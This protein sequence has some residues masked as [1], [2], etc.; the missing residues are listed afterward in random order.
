MSDQG[1][2][3]KP[4]ADQSGTGKA[5]SNQLRLGRFIVQKKLGQGAFGTV[6]LGEDVTLKRPVALK[7]FEL[8][9]LDKD[10]KK[11]TWLD[12]FIREAR[13]AAQLMHPSIT[14]VFEVGR[15][16]DYVYIAM[17]LIENGNL[18]EKVKKEGPLDF[19]L[20]CEWCA[21][22]AEGLDYAHSKGITHRDIKPPNLMLTGSNHCKL[23]DFGLAQMEDPD[24]DFKLPFKV[25]GTPY[26]MAPEV[27]RGK[28]GKSADIFALGAVFWFLLTGKPPFP[29]KSIKDVPKVHLE[30]PLPDLKSIRPDV[31]RP[32]VAAVERALAYKEED[33]F[34]TPG[35]FAKEL[36]RIAQIDTSD[37]DSPLA[38][39]HEA[40][41]GSSIGLSSK[42]LAPKSGADGS[43]SGSRIPTSVDMSIAR[44]R[45]NTMPMWV[46]VVAAVLA[47]LVFVVPVVML[48]KGGEPE[49]IEPEL[50]QIVQTPVTPN[51]TQRDPVQ[52]PTSTKPDPIDDP[53]PVPSGPDKPIGLL[54]DGLWEI[55]AWHAAVV[56]RQEATVIHDG[57]AALTPPQ[58]GNVTARLYLKYD[59]S[60]HTGEFEKATITIHVASATDEGT[61]GKLIVRQVPSNDWQQQTLTW[62]NAPLPMTRL[63]DQS[64]EEIPAAVEFDISNLVR[65]AKERDHL[66]S[67]AVDLEMSGEGQ[68]MLADL[69]SIDNRPKLTIHPR[70]AT[71]AIA[72]DIPDDAMHAERDAA[73]IHQLANTSP[74]PDVVIVGVLHGPIKTHHHFRDLPLGQTQMVDGRAL[75]VATVRWTTRNEQE[76]LD[77]L[78]KTD[79]S[80]L[81][82]LAVIVRTTIGWSSVHDGPF[83]ELDKMSEIQLL[84]DAQKAPLNL[85][86]PPPVVKETLDSDQDLIKLTRIMLSGTSDH[87][88][89]EGR[90]NRAPNKSGS[91]WYIPLGK[92]TDRER[93]FVINIPGR[94]EDEITKK[95]NV[96]SMHHLN[97][98][99]ISIT[100]RVQESRW[101][102]PSITIS[103]VDQIE[104]KA[105]AQSES[106]V[107]K[108]PSD[109]TKPTTTSPPDT[110][111]VPAA[112][113]L[114]EA[115]DTAKIN[116]ILGGNDTTTYRVQVPS[117][118]RT[119]S[120]RKG[121]RIL[122]NETNLIV[123]V[124]PGQVEAFDEKFGKAGEKLRGHSITVTGPVTRDHST[125]K[126]LV[127]IDRIE[128]LSSP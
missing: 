99:E 80:Q 59:L 108:E 51:P 7:L 91:N 11:K 40:I 18:E 119:F 19:R 116:E 12:Q 94:F 55:P 128:H 33:R 58:R 42:V 98:R 13:S 64:L 24:D 3:L 61:T 62:N 31:P 82:G 53:L 45:K 21:Q 50:N 46:W 49:P 88:R 86:T 101:K 26:F 63:G 5:K 35:D 10:K 93:A 54:I 32:L 112:P 113:P 15:S 8:K 52:P 75:N 70:Q 120:Y 22:A 90:I 28:G 84:N 115:T 44:R 4:P 16:K 118:V 20:A 67:L 117:V 104:E 77:H 114:I 66:V 76:L 107:T 127:Y 6:V 56:Y 43:R 60:G 72:G 121:Y 100:G 74:R 68:I 23:A 106:P 34:P 69:A 102:S 124:S 85:T 14:Q 47:I 125:Q 2:Q 48:L 39:L 17:E 38:E 25:V 105:P 30:I 87:Y 9:D 1:S 27:A 71:P 29:V 92:S 78:G 89:V 37:I 36:K 122:S 96:S 57:P 65:S 110:P 103:D 73:R 111:D 95:F 109:T 83:L 41:E 123:D 97:G 79:V 126:P 81:H